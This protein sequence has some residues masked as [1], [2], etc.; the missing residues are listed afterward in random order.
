MPDGSPVKP[1]FQV[2]V[3]AFKKRKLSP[4]SNPSLL[5]ESPM[6]KMSQGRLLC[7]TSRLRFLDKAAIIEEEENM[8][9]NK[10]SQNQN[11]NPW[12]LQ[13]VTRVEE[14][15]LVL[16]TIPIWLTSLTFGINVAQS[17]TFFVKQAATMN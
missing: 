7:N 3:A 2:L 9:S 1:L 8:V 16:N 5:Y 11:Q 13:T 10:K 6:S 14:M 4:P 12:R 15:K 17:S